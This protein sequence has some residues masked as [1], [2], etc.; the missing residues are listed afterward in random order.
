MAFDENTLAG[1]V[2]RN[3]R[4]KLGAYF[5]KMARTSFAVVALSASGCERYEITKTDWG[6]FSSPVCDETGLRTVVGLNPDVSYDYVGMSLAG[7]SS[8]GLEYSV[9]DEDGTACLTALEPA[10]CLAELEAIQLGTCGAYVTTTDGDTVVKWESGEEL[11]AFLGTVDTA[12][13]AILIL[14]LNWMNIPCDDLTLGGVR[15]VED[16]F[17]VIGVRV[18]STC[19][20]THTRYLMHVASDGA[21]TELASEAYEIN[22]DE[23]YVVGRRPEGLVSEA[24]EPVGGDMGPYFANVAALEEAAVAAFE[25]M[26]D[27]LTA[28]SAPH[29]LVAGALDAA[30]EERGHVVRV[31]GLARRFG[32]EPKRPTIEARRER[33]LFDIA[34]ENAVEGCVRET[35]GALVGTYQALAASEPAVAGEMAVI[36]TEEVGHAELSWRVGDFLGDLLTVEQRESIG[37][38][39]RHAIE[40]LRAEVLTPVD[41]GLERGVGLPSSRVMLQWLDELQR[42]LWQVS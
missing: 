18:T 4:L 19:P 7:W 2:A 21:V 14:A 12:Q 35:F 24:R 1:L 11:M 8:C 16:G 23:C 42:E 34:L 39:Q 3:R 30:D 9:R 37:A 25:R 20:E 36:A 40:S 29:E 27:E 38:A 13:E 5:G 22:R 15:A 33:K 31:S 26:A 6:E 41:A 17:E 32:A 28:L 10:T